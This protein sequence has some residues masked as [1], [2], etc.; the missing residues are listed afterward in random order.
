VATTSILAWSD[1]GVLIEWGSSLVMM[2]M[3]DLGLDHVMMVLVL[4]LRLLRLNRLAHMVGSAV[5]DLRLHNLM[6]IVVIDYGLLRQNQLALAEGSVVLDHRLLRQ[7]R[8]AHVEV[9]I[10]LNLWLVMIVL[11]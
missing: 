2:I 5:L 4:D 6:V 3:L 8:L 11:N 1:F 7:N 10:A 9:M